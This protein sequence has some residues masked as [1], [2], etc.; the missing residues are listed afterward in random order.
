MLC[1]KL[2]V[3]HVPHPNNFVYFQQRGNVNTTFMAGM[4]LFAYNLFWS[5]VIIEYFKSFHCLFICPL[6]ML[7][8]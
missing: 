4:C 6:F 5:N 2:F 8:F 3:A 7:Q 1:S